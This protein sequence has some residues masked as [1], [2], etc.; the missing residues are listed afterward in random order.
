MYS[1]FDT[2]IRCVNLISQEYTY[3]V[4]YLYIILYILEKEL[5]KYII[6]YML[7]SFPY[8]WAFR[9][10][11]ATFAIQLLSV[12]L[13][14][15]NNIRRFFS[16]NWCMSTFSPGNIFQLKLRGPTGSRFMGCSA[17]SL[18]EILYDRFLI[19][20]APGFPKKNS[21]NSVQPFSQLQLTYI[22]VQICIIN[23][24]FNQ[25]TDKHPHKQNVS[26]T[27]CHRPIFNEV[28]SRHIY[29]SEKLYY[30]DKH[31]YFIKKI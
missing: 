24:L 22:Y 7:R 3:H 4:Q 16:F 17:L 28:S 12:A 5:R 18:S 8:L 27:N 26:L 23:L 19:F 30:I 31:I 14:V 11:C 9:A 13:I 1:V 20:S 6:Y 29:M 21:A 10:I 15:F 2:Y 25:K